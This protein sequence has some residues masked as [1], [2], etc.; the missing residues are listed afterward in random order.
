M[1]LTVV[2]LNH[3]PFINQKL[4]RSIESANEIIVVQESGV[5]LKGLSS[6]IKVLYTQISTN[7][8]NARNL[9]LEQ[10]S[11]QWVL[12]LDSDEIPSDSLVKDLPK[13]INTNTYQ[14]YYLRRFDYFDHS[15]LKYG[16]TGSIYLLRLAKKS[17]GR[18]TRSVHESWKVTGLTI[19]INQPIYHFRENFVSSFLDRICL[20]GP[21][22]GQSLSR[23][24]KPF[25]Y[26]RLLVLPKAKFILNFILKRG[27]L[28]GYA[29]LF[30]AYLMSI[31]SLSV[32]VYQWQQENS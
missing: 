28:D 19:K 5:I 1:N 4:L 22:D 31:Q 9:A 25:S 13:L 27:F 6:Q 16:E 3:K 15:L 18:F 11:N 20:Y 10:A 30:H 26:L 29:G 8:A 17:S 32:R 14:G 7:F 2:I 23:E 21:L 24:D 12:F